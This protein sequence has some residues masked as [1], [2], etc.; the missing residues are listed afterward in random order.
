LLTIFG[1]VC[2]LVLTVSMLFFF[3]SYFSN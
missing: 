1:D 2:I 3:L